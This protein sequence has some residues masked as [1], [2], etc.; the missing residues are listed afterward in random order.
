MA[1]VDPVLEIY[2]EFLERYEQQ[3]L[4]ADMEEVFFSSL[5]GEYETTLFN[6]V[7]TSVRSEVKI[8]DGMLDRILSLFSPDS[9][10]GQVLRE[11]LKKYRPDYVERPVP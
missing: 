6:A 4:A 1:V 3:F 7:V 9:F 2:E 10:F 5:G 11:D 8:A